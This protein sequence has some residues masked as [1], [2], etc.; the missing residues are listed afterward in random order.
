MVGSSNASLT[1]AIVAGGGARRLGGRLKS[2]LVVGGAKLIDRQ[3]SVLGHVAEHILI[4]S[5]DL[6]RFRASGLR[7]CADLIP[8]AGPLSALYTALVRSPTARTLVVAGDLPF[9]QGPFLR[10]LVARLGHDDAAIPRD[11]QGWQPLCGVYD[12]ACTG[13]VHDNLAQGERRVAS[14]IPRIRVA[15][16]EPT[17]V[18]RFD[19]PD[20][21]FFNVNTPDDYVRA[22]ALADGGPAAAR[23]SRAHRP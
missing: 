13:P 3:L 23:A 10:Y 7:V 1:A 16:I 5:N 12:Q 20:R 4:V 9:L 17:D 18:A 8:D 6:H 19:D 15:A 22:Q 14:L 2:D 11:R 21:L